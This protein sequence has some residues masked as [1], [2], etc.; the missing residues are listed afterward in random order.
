MPAG[1]DRNGGKA[2]P[3]AEAARLQEG[4]HGQRRLFEARKEGAWR[5]GLKAGHRNVRRRGACGQDAIQGGHKGK[6]GSPRRGAIL[7]PVRS[8]VPWMGQ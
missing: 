7:S 5:K 3:E 8:C 2:V 4:S 6:E 1:E